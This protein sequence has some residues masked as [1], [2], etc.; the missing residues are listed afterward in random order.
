MSSAGTAGG[1]DSLRLALSTVDV[2]VNAPLRIHG[3]LKFGLIDR[4]DLRSIALEMVENK[5]AWQE[6]D[7]CGSDLKDN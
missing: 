6:I 4:C 3:T 1:S 2:A 5:T 7:A